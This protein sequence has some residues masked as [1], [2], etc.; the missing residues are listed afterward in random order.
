MKL[1]LCLLIFSVTIAIISAEFNFFDD[2][3]D[4]DEYELA[5]QEDTHLSLFEL[6]EGLEELQNEM[7]VSKR[8]SKGG[9][10][11][12]KGKKKKGKG[13]KIGRM[14]NNVQISL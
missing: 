4:D 12:G 10:K 14:Y 3:D 8:G 7:T 5:P 11:K 13:K 1:A 2:D 9:K 6:I